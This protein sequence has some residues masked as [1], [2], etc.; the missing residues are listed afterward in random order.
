MFDDLR[1]KTALVSGA[2][3]STGIGFG[4]A[5]ALAASGMHVII[6]DLPSLCG[7][8][9]LLEQCCKN[10]RARFPGQFI[11]LALDV[12][13]QESV[14]ALVECIKSITPVLRAVVNNAGVMPRPSMLGET[15]TQSWEHT[16]DVNV[17]GTFRMLKACLPLLAE[18]SAV[19]NTASRAG[20]RPAQHYA[21]Y[22]ASKAAVI[23]LTKCFAV[24]YAHR[25]IRANVICPGQIMT[26][27]RHTGYENEASLNAVSVQ[28]RVAQAVATIPL[29]RIGSIEDVGHAV[30]YLLSEQSSYITGQSLN[31]CGGQLVEV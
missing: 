12:T 11:G 31:I 26:D 28:E 3:R 19:V 24:E 30:A 5:T 21:S 29:R 13:Q 7:P 22:S 15:S 16:M 2:G 25:G 6:T 8:D 20:K 10:L 4:I 23:M 9:S 14:D 1:G 27:L 17:H 18:G